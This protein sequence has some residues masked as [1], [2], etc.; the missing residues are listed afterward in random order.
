MVLEVY[1]DTNASVTAGI[2]KFTLKHVKR[3]KIVRD[4]HRGR[5]MLARREMTPTLPVPRP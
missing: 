5:A 3:V 4:A 1:A 2:R